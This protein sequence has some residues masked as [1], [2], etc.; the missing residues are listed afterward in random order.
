MCYK[1]EPGDLGTQIDDYIFRQRGELEDTDQAKID[2]TRFEI[3]AS[4]EISSEWVHMKKP[5]MV[6]FLRQ[7]PTTVRFRVYEKIVAFF[8]DLATRG[9]IVHPPFLTNDPS[10][11]QMANVS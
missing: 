9:I 5:E 2:L 10:P 3:F 4:S 11:L 6:G 8:E 7:Q 1:C